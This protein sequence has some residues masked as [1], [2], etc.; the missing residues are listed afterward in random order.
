VKVED[1]ADRILLFV[2]ILREYG[3]YKFSGTRC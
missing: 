2:Q 1:G 3:C